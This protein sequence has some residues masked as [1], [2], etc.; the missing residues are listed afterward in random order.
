MIY[1]VISYLIIINLIFDKSLL[2]AICRPPKEQML[3][4]DNSSS[5]ATMAKEAP[6]AVETVFLKDSFSILI[7]VRKTIKHRG[8][9]IIN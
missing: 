9:N 6:V 3:K 5:M 4:E 8:H 7:F 2:D 1:H